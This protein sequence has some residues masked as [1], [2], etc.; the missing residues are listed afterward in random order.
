M[1]AVIG[2]GSLTGGMAFEGLNNLGH[3]GRR[4]IIVLNDNGRSYAPTASQLSASLI[5]LRLDPRV[6]REQ[7]R[8]GRIV[9]RLPLGGHVARSWNATK[10]AIREMWEPRAF[11]EDLG[12]RYTGPVDG[13]DLPALEKALRL[14]AAYDEGPIVL[15][16][17]TEKGRGYAPA[18][19]DPIKKLHDTS[20]FKAGSYTAAFAEALIKEAEHR[21]E[22]VAI[23]AA[24]PD[25]TGLL[26]FAERFPERFVDVGIAEQHAVTAAAGMAMGGLRPGGRHLLH[27]PHPGLRPGESRR[28]P[29]S[30]AGR[31]LPGPGRHH[32]RRRALPPRHPRPGAADQGAGHDR[33]LPRRRTR[34]CRSCS[35]TRST[36]PPARAPS[37]GPRPRPATWPSGRWARAS[38]ARRVRAG[39]DVCLVGVGKM[40]GTCLEAAE[41]LEAEGVAATVW[42]PRVVKP[43]DPALV[44]DAAEHPLVVTV[45]DGLVDGGAGSALAAAVCVHASER[46]RVAPRGPT[47]GRSLRL[48]AP[49]QARRDP[50]RPGPRRASGWR[51]RSASCW[52]PAAR[53]AQPAEGGSVACCRPVLSLGVL[54][55]VGDGSP[56]LLDV[57]GAGDQ[58]AP[59]HDHGRH[60]LDARLHGGG[61]VPPDRLGQLGLLRGPAPVE[62]GGV[63]AGLAGHVEQ[64]PPVGDRA[65]LA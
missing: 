30:P 43:L 27:V 61:V 22:V 62:L 5:R 45:E 37:A 41:L 11:F 14:A 53:P 65:V 38:H 55:G 48:S 28:R 39:G 12:V 57:D 1:V 52:P 19:N 16:V 36:S 4:A 24:M 26:P 54:P 47:A 6:V 32:R 13:H 2:D 21:P 35:T 40:L 34:S 51:T 49:R 33:V 9:D 64:H 15:H 18:E 44:A 10:A 8:V 46:G 20:E 60:P 63:E 29:A 3:S 7:D 17:L 23:T 58:P 42:D 25:S 59:V 50:G 31:V 56:V